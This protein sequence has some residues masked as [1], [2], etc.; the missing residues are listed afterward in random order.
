MKFEKQHFAGTL[1]ASCIN[2]PKVVFL[3]YRY[4]ELREFSLGKCELI[5][6]MYGVITPPHQIFKH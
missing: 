5:W 4:T 6:I 3:L 1:L 2:A